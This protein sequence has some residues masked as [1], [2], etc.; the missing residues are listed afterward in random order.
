MS[1][2]ERIKNRIHKATAPPVKY[3]VNIKTQHIDVEKLAEEI[4]KACSTILEA[5]KDVAST[6]VSSSAP[7]DPQSL[8]ARDRI[9][10]VTY[11]FG[12][13]TSERNGVVVREDGSGAFGGMDVLFDGEESP[14][15][16]TLNP[17]YLAPEFH[18]EWFL[19]HRPD[20]VDSKIE[21]EG[22]V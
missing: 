8:Q 22:Q 14:V 1:L 13:K 21:K 3:Q 9:R 6:G 20:Y 19:L 16:L 5:K 12:N 10:V 15:T 4:T 17:R 11:S 18:R 7:V 2:I